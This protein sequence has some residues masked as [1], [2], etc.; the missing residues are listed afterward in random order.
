M[1]SYIITC[2][3]DASDDEVQQVKKHAIDQG[4]EIIHEYNLIKGFSVA[5]DKDTV[6]S[7][8]THPHVDNVEED[9]EVQTQ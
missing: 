9:S 2:K 6:T 4:G 8:E 1:P 7:L 5:F 3:P